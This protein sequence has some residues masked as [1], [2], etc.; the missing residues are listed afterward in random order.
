M[1]EKEEALFQLLR[2]I[3]NKESFIKLVMLFALTIDCFDILIEAINDGIL[4]E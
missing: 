4:S 1:N 3:A 2:K